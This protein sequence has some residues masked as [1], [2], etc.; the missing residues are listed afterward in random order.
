MD[1]TIKISDRIEKSWYERVK[2]QL[3]KTFSKE[4]WW[5]KVETLKN[6]IE[7]KL[8]KTKIIKALEEGKRRLK[9]NWNK[10]SSIF[11]NWNEANEW[12]NWS[13]E[14]RWAW[15]TLALQAA[16]NRINWNNDLEIDWIYD[17]KVKSAV[18]KFQ[19]TN[20]LSPDWAAWVKTLEEII[21][22]LKEKNK[23]WWWT[24]KAIYKEG[25]SKEKIN[26]NK[27][28]V[29]K[30][31]SQ[32]NIEP[33][34]INRIARE[35]KISWID[36]VILQSSNLRD[37]VELTFTK[38][39]KKPKSI[40]EWGNY[41][42]Q[43]TENITFMAWS[44]LKKGWD[45]YDLKIKEPSDKNN[46]MLLKWLI[47][48]TPRKKLAQEKQESYK[49]KT[50]QNKENHL[51]KNKS[52]NKKTI[53]DE[54]NKVN[55]QIIENNE[56]NQ[57]TIWQKI[58]N[59]FKELIDEATKENLER[60]SGLET[61]V[62]EL[63]NNLNKEKQDKLLNAVEEW[64]FDKDKQTLVLSILETMTDNQK[65]KADDIFNQN[66]DTCRQI[67]DEKKDTE[68]WRFLL[69]M[70]DKLWWTQKLNIPKET[71]KDDVIIPEQKDKSKENPNQIYINQLENADWNMEKIKINI[72]W[73]DYE[74]WNINYIKKS[75]SELKES[76]KKILS[77][78]EEINGWYSPKDKNR[79]NQYITSFKRYI[80][81]F[82]TTNEKSLISIRYAKL[83]NSILNNDSKL[84]W[85][86]EYS[87]AFDNRKNNLLNRNTE[88]KEF[89]TNLNKF[90]N[91]E[92]VKFAFW[93]DKW[94]VDQVK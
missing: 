46:F 72:K 21:N 19:S 36:V 93:E 66:I 76:Y 22:K 61:L 24:E 12:W 27:I 7:S 23:T 35:E 14:Y 17:T 45:D 48:L 31:K 70:F 77:Q 85:N 26:T 30:I 13:W 62:I 1:E 5:V 49:A 11:G 83:K 8:D 75:E 88:L 71:K 67:Y 40:F 51:E 60:I 59:E 89:E 10:F 69:E 82:E 91:G 50:N 55:N 81:K 80:S 73:K 32:Y 2:Q 20:W 25:I 54:N 78:K 52:P 68:E 33:A 92:S 18:S 39:T 41:T 94:K 38:S 9:E 3:E 56:A 43:F 63:I 74:I 86:I 6:N 15:F 47:S 34:N 90:K 87:Q 57:E 29:D 84:S 42:D 65:A 64:D 28:L 58:V 37:I 44:K 16:I 53:I 79:I 4:L